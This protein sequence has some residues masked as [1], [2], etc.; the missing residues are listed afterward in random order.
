MSL[1][2]HRPLTVAELDALQDFAAYYG[3][4]WKDELAFTYWYNARI[5]RD[6][7]GVN[8]HELHVLRNQLGPRWLATYAL[9]KREG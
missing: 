3:R 7:S 1:P 4:K 8:R 6:R 9:P 5:Y 2:K